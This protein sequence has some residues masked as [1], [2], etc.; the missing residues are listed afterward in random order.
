MKTE[1][2]LPQRVL[3]GVA[4]LGALVHVAT[5]FPTALWLFRAVPDDARALILAVSASLII[6]MIACGLALLLVVRAGDRYEARGLALFLSL[7]AVCWGSVLRFASLER[8]PGGAP[9]GLNISVS[10]TPLLLAI[11]AFA[12]AG[13][14]LLRLSTRFPQDLDRGTDGPAPLLRRSW[15]PWALAL[16][17]PLLLP[18]GVSLIGRSARALGFSPDTVLASLPWAL[19]VVATLIAAIVLGMV[20]QAI[21][22]FVRGFRLADAPSRRSAL[23]LVVGV[24]GSAL[25]VLASTLLLALDMALPVSLGLLSRYTPAIV[26]FAPLVMVV[27]VAVAILHAGAVD[28]RLALRRS[29]INGIAGTVGLLVFAGLENSLSAW[30]ESRLGL[31]GAIGSFLAGTISAGTFLP[32]QRSLGRRIAGSRVAA[33]LEESP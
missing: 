28:P 31:P 33:Q 15:V 16:A 24:V 13:A 5:L 11:L 26:L 10:G 19:G 25:L 27:C 32:V 29:T 21:A 9:T 12:L 30:V 14:A 2:E 18:P 6:A 20:G 22:N 1:D 4:A 23:W 3:V 17:T 7:I 8:G